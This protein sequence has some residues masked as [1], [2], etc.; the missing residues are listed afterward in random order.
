[1]KKLNSINYLILFIL[2]SNLTIFILF[3][4]FNN[5]GRLIQVEANN[6][7]VKLNGISSPI[8]ITGNNDFTPFNGVSSGNGTYENPFIIEDLIIEV[9]GPQNCIIINNTDVFFKIQNC[10]LKNSG[11]ATDK[12]A[13]RFNNVSYGS[14][15]N[16]TINLARIF[17]IDSHNN[18][19][20]G[21]N[22]TDDSGIFLSLSNNNTI[23]Y[24]SLT[25]CTYIHL[26]YSD[27]NK[28]LNN[29]IQ[30][31]TMGIRFLHSSD[32]IIMGNEIYDCQDYGIVLW[33]ESK[34]N[35]IIEN[36]IYNNGN[37][38]GVNQIYIDFDSTGTIL[39]GNIYEYRDGDLPPFDPT[40]LL[41]LL[42]IIIGSVAIIIVIS[43]LIYRRYRKVK[44]FK[45]PKTSELTDTSEF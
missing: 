19:I 32:N 43:I 38:T 36:Y 24:N 33:S 25:G 34:N 12:T 23:S 9:D 17:L 27:N 22:F 31:C 30:N 14:I 1:M 11:L 28:I 2:F 42:S 3:F 44:G 29:Y 18:S 4:E 20:Y 10:T 37:K 15:L 5:Y 39:S 41:I 7:Q 26:L 8:N 6:L 35:Q 13:I 45:H 16:N 21:N 40:L